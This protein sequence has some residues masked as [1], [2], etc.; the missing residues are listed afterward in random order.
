MFELRGEAHWAPKTFFVTIAICQ[1][2]DKQH[3]ANSGMMLI[4]VSVNNVAILGSH[5][6]LALILSRA[7]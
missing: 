2:Y 4:A 7:M 6:E 1:A 5:C 3:L